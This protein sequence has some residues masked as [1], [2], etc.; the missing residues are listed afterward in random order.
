MKFMK[1]KSLVSFLLIG[2]F[3]VVS[4]PVLSFASSLLIGK[5]PSDLIEIFISKEDYETLPIDKRVILDE[6]IQRI[7]DARSGKIALAKKEQKLFYPVGQTAPFDHGI[8]D[9]EAPPGVHDMKVQNIWRGTVSNKKISLYAG[10]KFADKNQGVVLLDV[11]DENDKGILFK[12]FKTPT[13]SGSV[14]VIGEAGERIT[15]QSSDGTTFIFN[16][17]SYTFE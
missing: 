15:L 10:H 3:L 1:N 7:A 17:N 16:V 2:V 14:K 6:E 4:I 12:Q 9:A 8:M 11:M 13:P 5:M